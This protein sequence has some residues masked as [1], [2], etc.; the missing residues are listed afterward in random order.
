MHLY[1][2]LRFANQIEDAGNDWP[3]TDEIGRDGWR[4]QLRTTMAAAIEALIEA[5]SAKAVQP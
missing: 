1:A 3:D 4:Y 5:Q 2:V